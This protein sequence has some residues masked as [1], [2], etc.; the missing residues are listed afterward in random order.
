MP[1]TGKRAVQMTVE[2]MANTLPMRLERLPERIRIQKRDPVHPNDSTRNRWVM[3]KQ[4][5]GIR[6]IFQRGAQPRKTLFSKLP[7]M[8]SGLI[9]VQHDEKPSGRA[10]RLLYMALWRGGHPPKDRKKRFPF[11]MIAEQ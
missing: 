6:A 7:S 10:E 1:G 9:C 11:V 2:D 4:E 3:Q 5:N 8:G